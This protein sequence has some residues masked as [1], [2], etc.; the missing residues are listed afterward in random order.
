MSAILFLILRILL[1]AILYGFIFWAIYTL[2]QDLR[3]T[4]INIQ[5]RKAPAITL[6]VTNTLEDQTQNFTITEVIVGRSPAATYT[7]RNETVSSNHARLAFRQSQWWVEDLH[8]T[9]GTFLNE[10]RIFTP[11]VVMNGDDLRCGQVNIQVK[12]AE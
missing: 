4:A 11:T 6:S 10:E 8:S 9:N 1:A 2:W 12:I 7:I 3:S 5:A